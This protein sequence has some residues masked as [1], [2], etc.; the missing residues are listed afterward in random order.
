M[1][2]SQQAPW[3]FRRITFDENWEIFNLDK[4]NKNHL[5]RLGSSART[6]GLLCDTDTSTNRSIA[7]KIIFMAVADSLR[8]SKG[9]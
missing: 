1:E 7:R 8:F 9:T 4:L 6:F 2:I 5:T 3:V